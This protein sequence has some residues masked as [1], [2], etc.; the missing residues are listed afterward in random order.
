MIL[1]VA[2]QFLFR[3]KYLKQ[4]INMIKVEMEANFIRY[5]ELSKINNNKK[6]KL[7]N[8]RWNDNVKYDD[9]CEID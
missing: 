2:K 7:Y 6:V 3:W 5:L 9:V 1:L 4:N 8:K